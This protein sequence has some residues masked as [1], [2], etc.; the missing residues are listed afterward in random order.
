M[1]IPLFILPRRLTTA[2]DYRPYFP[3]S[4]RLYTII[5]MGYIMAGTC[6]CISLR[7]VSSH[8][9]V[10]SLFLSDDEMTRR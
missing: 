4:V 6:P 8:R 7:K 2:R 5:P 1:K 3:E 10:G 9:D